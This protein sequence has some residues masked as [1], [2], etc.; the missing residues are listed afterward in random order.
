ME[1]DYFRSA[2]LLVG[3]AKEHIEG[4]NESG[5][6]F[7]DSQPYAVS[8]D[9][10]SEAG[11]YVYTVRIVQAMP[12]SFALDTAD[13]L[14]NMKSALDQ[15][16]C[17][18]VSAIFPARTLDGVCFPFADIQVHFDGAVRRGCKKVASDI[19]TLLR[20]FQPYK[21]GNDLL[22]LMN[23]LSKMNRHRV[24]QPVEL[25]G[26]HSFSINR[27]IIN[28]ATKV[29]APLWDHARK[30]LIF[31]RAAQPNLEYDLNFI[32]H[33]SFGDVEIV[34]AQPAVP[35]LRR[36]ADE[37]D[38]IVLAIEAETQRV[39]ESRPPDCGSQS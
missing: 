38:R 6:A 13:A 11:E 33:I 17:A 19:V 16:V 31:A 24:L 1:Q 36:F 21:G 32:F 34:R 25:S 12:D 5:K 15:A 2:R 37:V 7:A 28:G 22:W 29:M 35:I 4:L 39:V 30:E 14:N 9:F 3:R 20:G 8:C 23:Q 26:K 10:D 27:M 18:S